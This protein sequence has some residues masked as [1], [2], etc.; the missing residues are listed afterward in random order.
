LRRQNDAGHARGQGQLLRVGDLAA[1]Q[2]Q[3]VFREHHAQPQHHRQ[4][5]GAGGE[6]VRERPPGQVAPVRGQ[7]F[8]EDRNEGDRHE[9]AGQEVIY[10]FRQEE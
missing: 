1:Q 5:H 3:E 2:A 10:Q 7:V 4:H 8:L 9:A 6:D